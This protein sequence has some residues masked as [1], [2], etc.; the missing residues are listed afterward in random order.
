MVLCVVLFGVLT[1]GNL[2]AM[3]GQ[4]QGSRASYLIIAIL[5]QNTR[6]ET[7]ETRSSEL[8]VFEPQS[9]FD[10][11]VWW[12]RNCAVCKKPPSTKPRPI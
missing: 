5:A 9:G 2:G 12:S 3:K 8:S 10:K 4:L 1:T 7:S 11:N 6:G